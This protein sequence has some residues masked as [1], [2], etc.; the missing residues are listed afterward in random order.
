VF[1]NATWHAKPSGDPDEMVQVR[2]RKTRVIL[3]LQFLVVGTFLHFLA[4][5]SSSSLTN[6]QF[7]KNIH[8]CHVCLCL[9]FIIIFIHQ[10]PI[11]PLSTNHTNQPHH[12]TT[13]HIN[14]YPKRAFEIAFNKLKTARGFWYSFRFDRSPA[15]MLAKLL[16]MDL[17]REVVR[18]ILAGVSTPGS[19]GLSSAKA[20]ARKMLVASCTTAAAGAWSGSK[21]ALDLAK[22][23][24][25]EKVETDTH[26]FS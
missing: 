7:T 12:T 13:N 24:V 23:V 22:T 2:E 17:D 6:T 19:I 21:P 16:V 5:S 10:P 8:V 3:L 15:E 1:E 25:E 26:R 9:I 11:N 14:H 20:A 18:E 4:S